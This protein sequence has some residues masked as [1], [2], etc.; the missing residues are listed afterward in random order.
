MAALVSS[1]LIGLFFGL[2]PAR[3]ASRLQV[4]DCLRAAG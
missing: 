2:V 3:K 4:V 1:V